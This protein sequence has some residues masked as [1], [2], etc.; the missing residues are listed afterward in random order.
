M[1]Y[2]TVASAIEKIIEDEKLALIDNL[3]EFMKNRR[4]IPQELIDN[5]KSNLL[6]KKSIEE[7]VIEPVIREIVPKTKRSKIKPIII[8]DEPEELTEDKFLCHNT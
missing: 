2:P 8:E 5:F 3:F 6:L 4:T 1:A 7:E